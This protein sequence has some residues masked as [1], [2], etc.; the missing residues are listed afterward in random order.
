MNNIG[1]IIRCEICLS[2][3]ISNFTTNGKNVIVQGEGNRVDI[4]TEL[5]I[6]RNNTT[7]VAP[8]EKGDAGTCYNHQ[9]GTIIPTQSIDNKLYEYIQFCIKSGCVIRYTGANEH[10]RILG[11]KDY[12]LL[13]TLEET[14]GSKASDLAGY[15]LILSGTSLY[16]ALSYIEV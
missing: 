11:T 6:N 12:P 15:Q 16:P 14:S 1:G 4:W 2:S 3:E 9:F 13:G 5:P 7:C 10:V 8:P